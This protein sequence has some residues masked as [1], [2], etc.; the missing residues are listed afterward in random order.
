MTKKEYAQNL[1]QKMQSR[2]LE[3]REQA[4]LK[5]ESAR[6]KPMFT[7]SGTKGSCYSVRGQLG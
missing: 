1:R 3:K 4:K 7:S 6:G 5:M 2:F